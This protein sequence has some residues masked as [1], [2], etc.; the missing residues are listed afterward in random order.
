M[1]ELPRDIREYRDFIAQRFLKGSGIEIGAG[2]VP[3]SLSRDN[4]SVRYVDYLS[5][6]DFRRVYPSYVDSIVGADVVDDGAVLCKFK[7]H[8][9]DFIAAC[10]MLEHTEDPIGVLRTWHRKLKLNG[11]AYIAIP[12]KRFCFDRERP[13][14]DIDHFIRDHEE[15]PD[16][17]RDQHFFEFTRLSAKVPEHLLEAKV[18]E[19]KKNDYRIHFHTWTSAS[20]M[21]FLMMFCARYEPFTI[22]HVSRNHTELIAVLRA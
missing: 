19:F 2:K 7:D 20:F 10:H 17:S 12:D 9:L 8:S 16:W 18:N 13:I 3:L 1:A 21:E 5:E 4:V 15:G 22:E 6:E 11:V 14:T